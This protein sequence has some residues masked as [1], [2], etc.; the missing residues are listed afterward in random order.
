LL[1]GALRPLQARLASRLPHPAPA[2]A[3]QAQQVSGPPRRP[4]IQP[5]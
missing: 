3:R 4:G 2:C 1:Q 5:L